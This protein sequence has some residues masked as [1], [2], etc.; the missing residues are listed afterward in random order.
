MTKVLLTGLERVGVG[1]KFSRDKM[2]MID[3]LFMLLQL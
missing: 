2:L 3:Y 1:P